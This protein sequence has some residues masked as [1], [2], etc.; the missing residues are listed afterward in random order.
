VKLRDDCRHSEA[1]IG[2]F[3]LLTRA[4][5]RGMMTFNATTP[6]ETWSRQTIARRGVEAS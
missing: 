2:G 1:D 5:R 6:A 4:L 3:G